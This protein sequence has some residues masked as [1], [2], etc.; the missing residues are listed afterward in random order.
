M[1]F[2]VKFKWIMKGGREH[3]RCRIGKKIRNVTNV[4]SKISRENQ[5]S[6]KEWNKWN[7]NEVALS[8]TE[9]PN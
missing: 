7:L 9:F 1:A 4:Y 6:R 5:G 8:N 3:R 2:E